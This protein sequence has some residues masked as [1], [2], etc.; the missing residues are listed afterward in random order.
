MR[1]NRRL[2]LASLLLPSLVCA[3][4]VKREQDFAAIVENTLKTGEIVWLQAGERSFIALH[5][6]ALDTKALGTAI[7]LHDR[8]GY[9][10][11][12]VLIHALRTTLPNHRWASLSLQAP[13]REAGAPKQDYDALLPEAKSRLEAAVRFLRD[14]NQHETIVVVGYGLGALMGLYSVSDM[15]QQIGALVAISLPM[16]DSEDRPVRTEALL[17]EIKLPVLDIYGGLD[18]SEVVDS[19]RNRRLAAKDNDDYRQDRIANAGHAFRHHEQF[20]VQRVY[21]WLTRT[22]RQP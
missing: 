2:F 18:L 8:D 20:L 22:F 7:I 11:Q 4:D 21:G 9:P 19:A 1:L 5:T 15:Q 3:S 17:Q 10:D 13:V 14:K 16:Y 12:K 6:E